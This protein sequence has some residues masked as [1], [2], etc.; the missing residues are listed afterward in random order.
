MKKRF[1]I[2]AA[3][4]LLLA[5]ILA[6]VFARDQTRRT[7]AGQPPLATVAQPA[8]VERFWSDFD[9]ASNSVRAVVFL[10]PT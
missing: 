6:A 9:L 3:S 2:L 1:Q 5:L 4:G 7:P 10:S 8:D